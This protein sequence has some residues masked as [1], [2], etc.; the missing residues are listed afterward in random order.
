MLRVVDMFSGS[1]GL[2]LGFANAGF[3][4]SHAVDNW[5]EALATF[6]H[7][8]PTTKTHLM[9]LSQPRE[10]EAL[11]CA[12]GNVDVIVG[13]PPCQGF[14]IAGK[15]DPKDPRNLL[16]R[17]FTE[18]VR[19]VS[20]HAFVM[21]NVPTIASPTNRELFEA[22]QHDF[23]SL[24]YRVVARVLLASQFGVPQNRK[25]MFIVGTTKG[26]EFDFP[27]PLPGLVTA[28]DAIGDLPEDSL[29][30][31]SAYPSQPSSPFQELMRVDSSGVFNHQATNHAERTIEVIAQVPDGGNYKN[32]PEDLQGTRKVNIAWTRLSS[33]RPSFTIDTG[34]RHHFHYSYNRVPTAR[35]SARLQSFPDSYVFLGSRSSQLRQIG[36]AVPPLLAKAIA[37]Q[38]G[39]SLS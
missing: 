23:V 1:G 2:S 26:L 18:M 7:N 34:H 12:V 3:E 33:A 29:S 6:A 25:R 24:G 5:H 15:R 37:Q 17:G 32:L 28:R 35:E 22:I 19:L 21:E 20:P 14:S 38:L 9:D 36:N 30:D 16:Y 27:E 4:V 10:I 8:K 11:A 39:K 13:G 31:G